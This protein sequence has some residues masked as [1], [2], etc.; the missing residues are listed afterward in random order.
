[1]THAYFPPH[2]SLGWI[3]D[4]VDDRGVEYRVYET[5][6]W[7]TAAGR[8]SVEAFGKIAAYTRS[9]GVEPPVPV[10]TNTL[11]DSDKVIV[12]MFAYLENAHPLTE[13]ATSMI[14]ALS[15]PVAVFYEPRRVAV[16]MPFDGKLVDDD[17]VR[18][19]TAIFHR[20]LERLRI[21]H[22][23]R[24][25]DALFVTCDTST[26]QKLSRRNEI[27]MFLGAPPS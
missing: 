17:E 9:F 4:G 25:R 11:A 14:A 26:P 10:M 12:R 16:A 22:T 24:W 18:R 21:R 13:L 7:I 20:V 19:Q 5:T 6:C 27:V 8:T 15:T 2:V 1:M 3:D 23:T